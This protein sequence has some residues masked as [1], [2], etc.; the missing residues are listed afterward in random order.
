MRERG[1][2]TAG[3]RLSVTGSAA[4]FSRAGVRVNVTDGYWPEECSQLINGMK[5]NPASPS[6]EA[7]ENRP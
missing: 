3:K 6:I 7:P 4:N 1:R 2:R 5:S